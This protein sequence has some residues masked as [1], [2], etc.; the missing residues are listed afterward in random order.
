MTMLTRTRV[1]RM[2]RN[3]SVTPLIMETSHLFVDAITLSKRGVEKLA[4]FLE[5]P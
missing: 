1:L 5:N 2:F 3:I 4:Y